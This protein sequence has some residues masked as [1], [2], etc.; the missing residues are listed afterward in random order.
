MLKSFQYEMQF[1][2]ENLGHKTLNAIV[3]GSK[4]AHII[5]HILKK[6]EPT[7]ILEKKKRIKKTFFFV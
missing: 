2:I 5:V 1:L 4:D 6:L 7:E 3:Y